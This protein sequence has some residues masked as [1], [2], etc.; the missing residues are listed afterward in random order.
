MS[1]SDSNLAG[2]EDLALWQPVIDRMDP[3]ARIEEQNHTRLPWLIPERHRRMA[4]SPFAWFRG[5]AAQMA[6]DLAPL[7][8]STH[9]VQL[10]G[11]AHLLN[12]GF[13]ASPERSLVFDINDFDE[14]APG[15]FEWDVKRLLVSAVL[16]ARQW[17]LDREEQFRLA[18]K[19]AGAYRKAMAEYA[20]LPTLKLWNC[21]LHVERFVEALPATAFR[22]HLEAAM[23]QALRR[24]GRHAIQKHCEFLPDGTAQ[25][26]HEPPLI[27]RHA[28]LDPAQLWI[29]PEPVDPASLPSHAEALAF[30]LAGYR[31]SLPSHRRYQLQDFAM[32]DTAL[33]AVGVGSVGT[34]CAIGL[35]KGPH[36]EDWLLLQSK[37]ALPSCISQ[38]LGEQVGH[39][40]QRVVEGQ[41][42][43]QCVCDR[44][45]GWTT[46][47]KG[48]PLYWRQFRDWKASVPLDAM[49]PA[50][51]KAY[52][53]LCASVLARAH[54]RSGQRQAL[55]GALG[56]DKA[57]DRAMASFAVAYSDQVEEDHRALLQAMASGRLTSSD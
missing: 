8:R 45:L 2:W 12:F 19:V 52:A 36:P 18:R 9:Q 28:L 46:T 37:Q 3:I 42:L 34:R 43:I 44:F 48:L 38:Q 56:D 54:A 17:Q 5:T 29:S 35:M 25:I 15:P 11:D 22:S 13:Y 49:K 16:V 47:P 53:K 31:D 23:G 30:L 50:S 20:S 10:C 32:I 40:G 39:E 1:S 24:S 57:F 55:H 21:L 41:R 7:P 27:W 33:K 4:E 14:T 26:R 51:L 6:A